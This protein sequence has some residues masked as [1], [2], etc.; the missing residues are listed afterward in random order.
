MNE[1]RLLDV[2]DTPDMLK[3]AQEVARSGVPV[4]LKTESEELAVL[5]PAATLA[6]AKRTPSGKSVALAALR[7]STLESTA[8]SLEP[9]TRT[10][11][12]EAMIRDAKEEHAERTMAKL[13]RL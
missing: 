10:E 9:V 5:V 3:L 13:Q 12:F 7:R 1:P 11:D 2:T 6:R 4:M 8:A